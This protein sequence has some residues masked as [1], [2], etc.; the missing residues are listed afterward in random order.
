MKD[1][2]SRIVLTPSKS[3]MQTIRDNARGAEVGGSSNVYSGAKRVA[4][5]SIN[6]L[7]GQMGEWGLSKLVFN[8]NIPYI[9]SRIHR[10]ADPYASDMGQDLPGLRVDSKVTHRADGLESLTCVVDVNEYYPDWIYVQAFAACVRAIWSVVFVGW[11]RSEDLRFEENWRRGG[12]SYGS[13]RILPVPQLRPIDDAS[14]AI[15]KKS[16]APEGYAEVRSSL[17]REG[18]RELDAIYTGANR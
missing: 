1:L 13:K 12:Q 5:L 18:Q 15:W 2:A 4:H 10:N 3:E 6:Q 17:S 11:A 14:I 8:S 9:A 7:C 16:V